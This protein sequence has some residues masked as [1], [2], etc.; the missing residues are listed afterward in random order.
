MTARWLSIQSTMIIALPSGGCFDSDGQPIAGR[1]QVRLPGVSG[2]QPSDIRATPR[3]LLGSHTVL[4][5]E[6]RLAIRRRHEDRHAEP[7]HEAPCVALVPRSRQHDSRLAS[8]RELIDLT[9]RRQGIEQQQTVAVVDRIGGDELVPR[10]ARSPVR[11][12][13]LPMPQAWPQLAYTRIVF[14]RA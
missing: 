8:G 4:L 13:R 10:L 5:H 14:E 3:S 2:E 6:I 1:V 12:R 11:V 7:L 9:R